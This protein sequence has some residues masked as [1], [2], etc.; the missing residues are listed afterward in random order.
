MTHVRIKIVNVFVICVIVV[1][2]VGDDSFIF[3][4]VVVVR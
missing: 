3:I 1:D 4:V 2:V